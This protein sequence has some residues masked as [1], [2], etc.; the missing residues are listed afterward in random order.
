MVGAGLGWSLFSALDRFTGDIPQ[1]P[2]LVAVVI[3]LMAAGVALQAWRTHRT[4][5]VQRLPIA[6]GRAVA[7]LVLGRTCL[8]AGA[9]LAGAYAAISVFLALR[10]QWNLPRE[11]LLGPVVAMVA[12]AALAVAGA[13]LERSCRI[14]RHPEED[15]TPP[16]VPGSQ[17]AAD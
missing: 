6:P 3:A 17:D 11:R 10:L 13:F 4:V 15:A 12:S 16:A 14:P 8:V 1:L 5:Q 7:L 9:A 2:V